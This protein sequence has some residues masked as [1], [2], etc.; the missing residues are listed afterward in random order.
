MMADKPQHPEP[1]NRTHQLF[2]QAV[3]R[4]LA[5]EPFDLIVEQAPDDLQYELAEYLEVVQLMQRVSEEPAPAP[6][7][8][9]ANKASFLAQARTMREQSVAAANGVPAPV[10]QQPR[11]ATPPAPPGL[12]ERIFGGLTLR[13]PMPSLAAIALLM[14]VLLGV[15]TSVRA[16]VEDALPGDRVY[17]VKEAVRRHELALAPPSETQAL[18]AAQDEDRANDIQQA[19]H[20]ADLGATFIQEVSE[21]TFISDSPGVYQFGSAWVSK[22]YQ[23]DPNIEAYVKTT[24]IGDLQPG[25]RVEVTY[26]IIPAQSATSGKPLVQG[27]ELRVIAPPPAPT[28]TPRRR[29]T[30]T[31]MPAIVPPAATQQLSR[32]TPI[33]EVTGP[34]ATAPYR[35]TP[36]PACVPNPPPGW[37]AY[38]VTR[39][40]RLIDL[41]GGDPIVAAQI[42]QVNCLPE[43]GII[44][45]ITL[46]IPAYPAA[47]T[48]VATPTIVQPPG[49]L[50]PIAQ[51]PAATATIPPDMTPLA[52]ATPS[53]TDDGASATATSESTA[54][55]TDEPTADATMTAAP[56]E[57]ATEEVIVIPGTGTPGVTPAVT[58]QGTPL[59]ATVATADATVTPAP[60]AAGTTAPTAT[61]VQASPT[62]AD[63]T[64][65]PV[66]PTLTIEAGTP[67]P[68]PTS[69]PAETVTPAPAETT[70]PTATSEG[71]PATAVA[72]GVTPTGVASS[73]VAATQPTATGPP[74]AATVTSAPTTGASPPVSTQ[75]AQV[76][77]PTSPPAATLI[78]S[79]T[80][81]TEPTSPPAPTNPPATAINPPVV[82][83]TVT[84]APPTSPP[85]ATN[86][87]PATQPPATQAP[88]INPPT[89]Q[90]TA[91]QT[92]PPGDDGGSSQATPVTD[93]PPDSNG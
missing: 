17:A 59:P 23:P 80:A 63:A 20:N 31:P 35:P 77:T 2:D 44:G 14:V 6:A 3:E 88:P 43:A 21:M 84:Q 4:L 15:T 33:T 50:T 68:Q 36:I 29:A 57:K 48:P 69:A 49:P 38:I 24:V 64:A 72:P 10:A 45:G 89:A 42:I 34:T 78:P 7:N 8:R 87:P 54:G 9:A 46:Y 37:V 32:A 93:P 76:A 70:L 75:P 79:P 73:T 90:P 74:S 26:R 56:T 53:P 62:P 19:A 55:P 60:T 61:P 66:T 85:A 11:P 22:S 1:N 28:A 13:S 39:Y 25:A 58:A 51:T 12:L 30:A 82:Q 27:V 83:P 67:T 16:A 5:N 86:P 65:I 40:D 81:P 52:T 47:P 92:P 71:T 41:A 18:A 91:T